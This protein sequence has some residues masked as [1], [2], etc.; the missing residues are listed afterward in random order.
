M[1]ANWIPIFQAIFEKTFPP[2]DPVFGVAPNQPLGCLYTKN[3]SRKCFVF[4]QCH[5]QFK[6]HILNAHGGRVHSRE[7]WT[8][9]SLACGGEIRSK[10]GSN[11]SSRDDPLTASA[12]APERREATQR[13]KFGSRWERVAVGDAIPP[14][15]VTLP[16]LSGERR[17]MLLPRVTFYKNPA[18]GFG[19]FRISKWER[20]PWCVA[21]GR[22]CALRGTAWRCR[23]RWR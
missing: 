18:S 8:L 7:C 2:W 14:R 22:R 16:Y 15:C 6:S 12:A 13:D 11:V 10:K 1:L 9:F 20:R 4:Y 19:R 5:C 3:S 17:L 23:A 21:R